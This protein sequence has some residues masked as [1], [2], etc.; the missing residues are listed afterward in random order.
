MAYVEIGNKTPLPQ[1]LKNGA[2]CTKIIVE[3]GW[4]AVRPIGEV[5][6]SQKLMQY[7]RNK[8]NIRR[9]ILPI[10]IE[11]WLQRKAA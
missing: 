5:Y 2:A 7:N 4:K 10:Q 8:R 11:G 6:F 1:S 9:M 3:H